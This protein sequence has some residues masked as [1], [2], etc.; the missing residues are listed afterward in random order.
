MRKTKNRG[1]SKIKLTN[2]S[3]NKKAKSVRRH[4]LNKQALRKKEVNL[5]QAGRKQNVK[6]Q[7]KLDYARSDEGDNID[8]ISD[9]EISD[10][11]MKQYLSNNSNNLSFLSTKLIS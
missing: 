8:E 7:K 10:D 4:K 11:E 6:T 3:T 9:E 5:P 1:I 2:K